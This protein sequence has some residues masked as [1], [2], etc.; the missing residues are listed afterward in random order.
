ML[1]AVI[2]TQSMTDFNIN[3]T[4]KKYPKKVPYR[5]IKRT[6]LG[7]RYQLSLNFIGRTRATTL[8]QQYRQKSYSPNVL[9]FPLDKTVGEIF[10]CP[11]VSISE[12]KSYNLSPDGYIAF[13]FIHGLL[14]L[15]GYDHGDNMDKLE[16]KYIKLFNIK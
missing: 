12:A 11:E 6:I 15:K 1:I 5:E 13:L 14:H 3:S 9:S 7:H 16:Q 4:V 2:M 8:N 10:I